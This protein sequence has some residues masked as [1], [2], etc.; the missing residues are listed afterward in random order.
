MNETYTYEQLFH[1]VYQVFLKM[2]CIEEHAILASRVLLDADMRG[3]DSHGVARLSGYVRLWEAGRINA[4]PNIKATNVL[5]TI[6]DF[7]ILPPIEI[8]RGEVEG[9]KA[10]SERTASL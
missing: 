9:A 2:G 1:F 4:T 5:E 10:L 6:L 7:M 8:L 3:V